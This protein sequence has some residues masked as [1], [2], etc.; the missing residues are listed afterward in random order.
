MQTKGRS[1]AEPDR[2]D[3]D[4]AAREITVRGKGGRLEPGVFEYLRHLMQHYP[5][6][7]FVFSIGSGLEEMERDYSFLFNSSLYHRISF[8]EPTAARADHRTRQ[9]LLRRGAQGGGEDPGDHI[10]ACL[11]HPVGLPFTVRPVGA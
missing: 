11:L 1:L 9:G 3:V 7:N 4:L 6:L 8:L 2:S 5:N 10:G